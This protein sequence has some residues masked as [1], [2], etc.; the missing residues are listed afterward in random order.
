METFKTRI[1]PFI[2]KQ[3]ANTNEPFRRNFHI[4]AGFRSTQEIIAVLLASGKGEK[5]V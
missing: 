3:E 2:L 4:V 1:I 5:W